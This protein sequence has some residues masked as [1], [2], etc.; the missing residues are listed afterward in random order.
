MSTFLIRFGLPTLQQLFHSVF[1]GF[2]RVIA[3]GGAVP[4]AAAMLVAYVFLLS[5]K[6]SVRC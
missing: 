6:K 3:F 4:V 1:L 2:D 5:R